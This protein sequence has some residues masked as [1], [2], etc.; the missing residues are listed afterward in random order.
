MWDSLFLK[1][2]TNRK[3]SVPIL[4]QPTWI[5]VGMRF[6]GNHIP[7]SYW[8]FRMLQIKKKKKKSHEVYEITVV[9]PPTMSGLYVEFVTFDRSRGLY[10][11]EASEVR[12]VT[13]G[14]TLVFSVKMVVHL[15]VE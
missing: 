10:Y 12:E 6:V 2:W 13:S 8:S 5:V 7:G 3:S 9:I 4:G 11:E 15:L 1:S 14:L